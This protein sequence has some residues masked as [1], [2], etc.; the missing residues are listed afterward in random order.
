MTL[1]KTINIKKHLD[2]HRLQANKHNEKIPRFRVS[3]S[4]IKHITNM[5]TA[6]NAIARNT[7]RTIIPTFNDLKHNIRQSLIYFLKTYFQQPMFAIFLFVMV[8]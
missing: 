3:L 5:T 7:P 8:Y 1:V 4:F 6:I 2:G